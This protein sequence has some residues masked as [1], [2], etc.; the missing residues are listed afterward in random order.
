MKKR[1]IPKSVAI[2]L[3][4]AMLVSP[5]FGDVSAE[6]PENVLN[7]QEEALSALM[8]GEGDNVVSS[9]QGTHQIT[10]ITGDVVTVTEIGEGK[11]VI[12]VKP[13]NGIEDKARIITVDDETFVIPEEAMPFVA[14]DKLDQDLF[15]ITELVKNGYTDGNEAT[16]PMIVQY[17]ESKVRA[18]T[19]TSTPKAPEGSKRTRVLESIRGAAVSAEKS[20]AKKFWD[21]VTDEVDPEEATGNAHA[22]IELEQGIE[23]IWLDGKVEAAL[24]Q[25]VP[26]VGAPIA[27]DLG[28]DGTG[29]TVAV[30]DTGIDP[31]HPDVSGKIKESKSF[32][33]GEDILDYH[34]HGTHV[35]SIVLGTGAASDGKKKGVAPGADLIV[36]K[37][38]SNSGSGLNSWIIDGME[39]AAENA[40]VV[41]MSLGSNEPSD[42]KDPMA[43][44]LNEITEA[45]GT[46]FVVAAGNTGG[47]ATIGS[48]GAADKALTIGAVS[49]TDRLASFSSKGPRI[50]DQGLK[51][52]LSAPGVGI[53]A[54]RSHYSSGQGYYSTKNGTSMATPHVAGA[55]A[56][57]KQKHPDW[58]GEDIKEALMSTTKKLNYLPYEIG[59]GRLDIPASL[60]GVR[61][62]G[63]IHFGFFDW[64]HEEEESVERIVTYTNDGDEP[65]TLDLTTDF[66]DKEGNAAPDGLIQLSQGQVTVPANGTASISVTADVDLAAAGATLQGHINAESEGSS[67]VHTSMSLVKER[68]LYSMKIRA[69]DRDGSPNLAYV[70][71]YSPTLGINFVRVDG[72]KELRLP[73]DTYSVTSMMDVDVETDHSGVAFVGNPELELEQDSI[74]EL[75]AREAN[76]VIVK[77]P[78]KAEEIYKRMDY[79][80]QFEKGIVGE[81]WT[82]PVTDD[83][84]Y[85]V[86]IEGVKEGTFEYSTRWR[87]FK[88]TLDMN[89]RGRIL[90]DLPQAGVIHLEGKHNLKVVYAGKGAASDYEGVDAGGK[91]VVIERSDD[92]TPFERAKAAIAAGAKLL[93]VVN[94][95][96]KELIEMYLDTKESKEHI[97]LAVTSVT[98]VDGEE[99][100][101]AAKKGNL[102][103]PL[104]GSPISPY[105][106][107]L[108]SV[109]TDSIPDE[110]LVYAPTPDEMAKVET[111]YHADREV[112]GEEHRFDFSPV[113][114]VD[115]VLGR[116]AVK[117]PHDREE[118]VSTTEGS[119]WYQKTGMYNGD[120]YWEVRDKQMDYDAGDRLEHNWFGSVVRPAFGPGIFYPYRQ[121]NIFYLNIPGW[122]DSGPGHSGFMESDT[123][124]DTKL[125]LYQEDKLV[126][127]QYGQALLSW[128]HNHPTERTKYRLIS[129]NV[130]DPE[131]WSTSIKAQT[132]WTFWS[133]YQGPGKSTVPLIELGYDIK[134]DIANR[135]EANRSIEMVLSA[136]HIEDAVGIGNIEGATL[137]VSFNEGQTWKDVDLSVEGAQWKAKIKHPNDPDGSVSLRASAWDDA[138]NSVKQ[139]IIKAYELK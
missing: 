54:A 60:G 131:L 43:Q 113:R 110:T 111:H 101:E 105:S 132:E 9:V 1:R 85:A 135:V 6:I 10:L 125:T 87:L 61:A 50:G 127:E 38:L 29:T 64:P 77:T 98:S 30:L 117:L 28:L 59:T 23:K 67:V 18:I 91:A 31:E 44:A 51:P 48:P 96:P 97:P 93:I 86:P 95:T 47:A 122:G 88:P 118:W 56:I 133:E 124:K 75:D 74:V 32:V 3:S 114:K 20:Q 134:T 11:S 121:G 90:E 115:R 106:Y 40:D 17:K 128:M 81:Q 24:E 22:E 73:P 16:V 78:K 109:Y 71:V 123:M 129:E 89:F 116:A 100:I 65:I 80:R 83:K 108:I 119:T 58:T 34:S 26:Q 55:A 112:W 8:K 107:D 72:E 69:I 7:G 79:I 103:L 39:W 14:A 41:N 82:L 49:K 84:I 68:E 37:V 104:E 45:T 46:L 63:S 120:S 21:A 15:N 57:L 12:E 70:T 4:A 25:S 62:T 36:G 92:V 137:E 5:A 35:A 42:G 2:A 139:E 102:V 99:L 27:W 136:E 52:D 53:I 33:P 138:G 19:S 76:E 130:R 94:D 13:A 66:R 126:K